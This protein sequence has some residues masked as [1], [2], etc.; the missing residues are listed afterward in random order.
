M[1]YL[2]LIP[3]TCLACALHLAA[4][5]AP[6][7]SSAAATLSEISDTQALVPKCC[8]PSHAI[9]PAGAA[10]EE[11]DDQELSAARA[12]RFDPVL[13]EIEGWTVHVDPDLL[14]GGKHE[15]V[16]TRALAM[17]R[18]H[19]ERIAIL[20]PAKQLEQMRTCEIW[21]EHDHPRLRN[22]QYHPSEEWL[23][24]N[25]H[26]PRLTKKV[27]ITQAADLFS[28]HH[29]LKH[30]AVIL[31]ELAHAYHDLILGFDEPR[32]IAAYEAA[33]DAGIY[34]EVLLYTGD[35]VPHYATTDHREYFAE[36]TEA[37]LYRNDFYP[38]V[39]AELKEHDPRGYELMR[40][41][42]GPLTYQ[43]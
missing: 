6:Q 12:H 23:L 35:Y 11:G 20:L 43:E 13:R 3:F 27:H 32:I 7:T 41:I 22:M 18:N 21:I 17:L 15:E 36:S 24:N 37:Y 28:R 25:G 16:G 2:I 29:M 34:D 39:A 40:E 30:P 8:A 31:H 33:M 1:R 9:R 4:T 10:D 14:P 38:F 19:L 5:I 26:D 42:W